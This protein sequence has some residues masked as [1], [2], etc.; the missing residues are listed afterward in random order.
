VGAARY[1]DGRGRVGAGVTLTLPQWREHEKR[2]DAYQPREGLP[3]LD[4]LS[5]EFVDA[6]TPAEAL[7][8]KYDSAAYLRPPQIVDDLDP[9]WLAWVFMSGRGFG[10]S[11]AAASWLVGRILARDAGDYALVAP[12]DDDVWD[13]QWRTMKELLPPWVRYVERVARGQIVF[14]DHGVTILTHSAVNVEYRG[15]NLRGAWCEE[16]VKWVRGDKLWRNMRLALRVKGDTPPRAVFTTTPPKEIDWLLELCAEKSTRVIRGE[17]RDNPTLDERAVAAAYESMDG[18]VEGERELKG[19]VVIGV[20]G[21]LFDAEVL[22]RDRVDEAPPLDAVVVSVDPAQS[23]RKTADPVGLV[24]VGFARGHLY[25]LESEGRN[26]TPEE[27]SSRAL[28]MA[29][30]H[31]AGKY[32]VEPTGA[33]E[34][35]RATLDAAMRLEDAPRLPIVESKAKGSK[36]DRASPLSKASARGRLHLVGRRHAALE[37]D[38]TTWHPGAPFSPGAMDALVHGASVLTNNWKALE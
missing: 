8:L 26:M 23:A 3:L 22:D 27:W 19:K 20:D 1:V 2:I 29:D 13:L 32:V 18:T 21:A 12:T 6:L 34:Y 31:E 25:V 9:E 38:L 4:L 16:P 14:P 36:A 17:M 33:G 15:P 24:A 30:D 11:Y 37:K 7:T 28:V 10:K 35:P 5:P